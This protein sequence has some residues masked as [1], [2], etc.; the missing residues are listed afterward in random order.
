MVD[1]SGCVVVVLVLSGV[2]NGLPWMFSF[3]RAEMDHRFG[4]LI[5]HEGHDDS[6]AI[7]ISLRNVHLPKST[8]MTLD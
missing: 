7:V 6:F 2:T 4:H 3:R 1:K 5:G 8:T